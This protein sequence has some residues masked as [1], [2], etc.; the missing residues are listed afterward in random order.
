MTPVP[1][2]GHVIIK[3]TLCADDVTSY[4]L[5][6]GLITVNKAPRLLLG[7]VICVYFRPYQEKSI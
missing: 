5:Y 7:L 2:V 6:L 1:L 3:V 4:L